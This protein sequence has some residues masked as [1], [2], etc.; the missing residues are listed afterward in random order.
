[1]P[2]SR[3]CIGERIPART[4]GRPSLDQAAKID[5]EVLLA[6]RKLFFAHGY[7]RTSMAMII[8]AAG[9]SKTTLYARYANK[10]DL[11]KA[12]VVYTLDR[13]GSK[14]LT[15]ERRAR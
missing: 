12:T 13:I 14:S 5:L 4:R 7:E 10:A 9:V 3:R 2:R 1:M 6:A 8:K 11:F 15:T